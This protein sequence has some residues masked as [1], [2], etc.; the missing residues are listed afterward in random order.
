MI[1]AVNCL[2]NLKFKVFN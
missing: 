2:D 1:L